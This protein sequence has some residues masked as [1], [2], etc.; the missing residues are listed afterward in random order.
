MAKEDLYS[1]DSRLIFKETGNAES[2]TRGKTSDIGS[3]IVY[4][5]DGT[6]TGD[7]TANSFIDY[8]LFLSGTYSVRLI[9][10]PTSFATIQYLID[11]GQASGV[12]IINLAVTT[13]ALVK[14][15]GTAYVGGSAGTTIVLNEEN[16]IIVTG[17]TLTATFLTYLAENAHTVSEGF[18]GSFDLLEIYTGTL[19]AEEVSNL[20]NKS[21]F[22]ELP[23]EN[24]VLSIDT[25]YSKV[26]AGGNAITN[27]DVEVVN[28]G[29]IS[30]PQFDGS[31]AFL[32]IDSVLPELAST[33]TG[34][35]V[36]WVKPVD[37]TF[38]TF[39]HIISFGD[40]DANELI[41][42]VC[43]QTTGKVRAKLTNSAT[44]EW[45]LDTD[46]NP[47][48]QGKYT[49]VALIQNGATPELFINGI[50]P[51]QTLT[52]P[53]ST[54][55]FSK[56]SNIDNGRIGSLNFLSGGEQFLYNGKI[57]NI[58]IATGILTP[59]QITQEYTRTKHLYG[60]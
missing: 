34:T 9:V 6:I 31:T 23:I 44:I 13:G 26:I 32:N 24:Q 17:I 10:T 2:Q 52:G 49:H 8:L 51:S 3:A 21:T 47:F 40:T 29:G 38:P 1:Q 12:G 18:V 5:P 27:T 58:K 20:A 11:C 16:E 50:S 30:V 7:G 45:T 41:Q 39:Q 48:T 59:A 53:D 54:A 35:W 46:A 28:D 42:L 25:S 22:K 60:H 56:P 37:I 55:W 14:S 15:S 36:A 43:L 33:T 19:T 4:N 57:N